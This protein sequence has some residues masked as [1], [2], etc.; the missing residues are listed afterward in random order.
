MGRYVA[1]KNNYVVNVFIWD[2]GEGFTYPDGEVDILEI[3][4]AADIGI[5]DLYDG[6]E[7]TFSRPTES[8]TDVNYPPELDYLWIPPEEGDPEDEETYNWGIYI[9]NIGD[10]TTID[11]VSETD[12]IPQNCGIL[13]R[14]E[15]IEGELSMLNT[16]SSGISNSWSASGYYDPVL[17]EFIFDPY[18]SQGVVLYNANDELQIPFEINAT[19][20]GSAVFKAHL[21]IYKAVQGVEDL[22]LAPERLIGYSFIDL[23]KA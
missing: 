21:R 3:N 14:M 1:L 2:G 22:S 20:E 23:I 15:I 7:E 16:D 11:A 6:V 18:V 9:G 19:Y 12:I 10:G 17:M 5:G 4:P 13:L 8:P